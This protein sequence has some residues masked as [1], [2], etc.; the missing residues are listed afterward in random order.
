MARS[1]WSPACFSTVTKS[2]GASA[3]AFAIS[4]ASSVPPGTGSTEHGGVAMIALVLLI[5]VC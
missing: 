1:N 2:V 4:T 3:S 5:R